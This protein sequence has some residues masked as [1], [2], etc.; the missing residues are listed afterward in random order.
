M[1]T[2][3]QYDEDLSKVALIAVCAIGLFVFII[4]KHNQISV[5]DKLTQG[6][7]TYLELAFMDEKTLSRAIG[8]P[9]D[10]K[11]FDVNLNTEKP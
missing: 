8:T 3:C 11:S 5:R 10:R 7:F 9:V 6:Q 1:K 2:T 4:A